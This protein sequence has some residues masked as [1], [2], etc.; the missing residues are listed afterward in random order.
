MNVVADAPW[1]V[2][3][4]KGRRR[5]FWV[6]LALCPAVI[7]LSGLFR[8]ARV[9]WVAG[10]AWATLYMCAALRVVMVKCPRCGE[11]FSCKW[12]YGNPWTTKCLHCGLK[13]RPNRAIQT[14]AR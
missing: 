14:D 3:E 2:D 8:S 10:L 13:L 4:I 9:G 5:F 11:H 12:Y 6:V 7:L 1:G